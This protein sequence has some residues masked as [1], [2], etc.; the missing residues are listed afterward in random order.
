[1]AISDNGPFRCGVR[2]IH[3]C[4]ETSDSTDAH[5]LKQHEEI[6]TGRFTSIRVNFYS[7]DG[8][9][10][11][12]R[13]LSN[14]LHQWGSSMTHPSDFGKSSAEDLADR[15][16]IALS[17]D[18]SAPDT[19][20]RKTGISLMAEM[21][22]G[23][24]IC[25][26]YETKKD[27]LDAAVAY[28]KA[29]LDSNEFCVWAI[30]EIIST[31][32]ALNALRHDVPNFDRHLAA[33]RIELLDGHDWYLEENEF[34]LKRITSGWD[35]KLRGALAKGYEGIRVSGNA[36]WLH[37]NHWKDF[38]EYERALNGSLTGQQMIALC[39]YS[40]EK[41]RAQDIL[42]IGSIHQYAIAKRKGDWT[43]LEVPGHKHVLSKPFAGHDLLT[44]RERMVLA[45][46]V[47]GDSSKEAAQTLNISPRTV[48]FHRANI[49]QKLAAKN[50]AE[51]L[52][53]VLGE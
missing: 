34:D 25:L 2:P 53:I 29:G 10:F 26:F 13:K 49:L 39:T 52:R 16:P 4:G 48:E 31:E 7:R 47:K 44:P 28:F 27:L 20:L 19:A 15:R 23:A 12:P 11:H 45:Q 1:M 51:V 22:W 30:S 37:T 36:F 24:H 35:D 21:P 6:G 46:I 32:D 42:N 38:C 43:F 9:K 3:S 40:L 14:G 17:L 8:N 50:T 5:T 18:K 33:G 41:S